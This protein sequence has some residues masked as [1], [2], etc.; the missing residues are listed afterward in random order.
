MEVKATCGIPIY[1]N[2]NQTY[3]NI[4][5]SLELKPLNLKIKRLTNTATL[6]TQ[7]SQ[8]A[9]GFD[10]YANITKDYFKQNNKNFQFTLN[11]DGVYGIS[12][13]P[14]STALIPTGI[15][16]E[17]PTGFFGA[18]YAR[19]GLASK[20]GLRPANCVGVVDSDYRGEVMVALHNDT[21]NPQAITHGQRIAQFILQPCF[22]TTITEVDNLSKTDRGEDGFG[23]TGK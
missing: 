6:P 17:I 19:S 9:A 4:N 18:I 8:E 23:S 20:Q 1:D 10:L 15:S 5:M 16:M 11:E 14:H 21:D 12:I 2:L 22:H 3:K 7:G 13:K